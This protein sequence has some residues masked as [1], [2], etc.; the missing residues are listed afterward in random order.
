MAMGIGMYAFVFPLSCIPLLGCLA[1]MIYRARNNE[2]WKQLN[3]EF[4]QLFNK[5]NFK[6]SFINL[7]WEIDFVGM[8]LFMVSLS[9]ILVPFTIAGG[10]RTQWQRAAIIVP[11]VIGFVLIPIAIVWEAKFAKA[12]IMPLQLMKDRGV[13]AAICIAMLVYW[14]RDMPG[15]ALLHSISCWVE[16]FNQSCYKNY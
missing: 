12:P 16:F 4:V 13:W 2:E 9:C 1:H 10:V 6:K 15:E 5:Q 7:F 3:H 11:L 14:I 8:I